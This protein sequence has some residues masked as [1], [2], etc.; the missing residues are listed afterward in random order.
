[1]ALFFPPCARTI[2]HE[3]KSNLNELETYVRYDLTAFSNRIYTMQ[4]GPMI[5]GRKEWSESR[6]EIHPVAETLRGNLI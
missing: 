1:M 2:S 6:F 5:N 4:F 3:F